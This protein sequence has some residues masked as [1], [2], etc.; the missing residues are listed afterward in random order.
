M[1]TIG[2]SLPEN[3][4]SSLSLANNTVIGAFDA[5]KK[6]FHVA[7]KV[8]DEISE[9]L[10]YIID[11]NPKPP[12]DYN[13]QNDKIKGIVTHKALYPTILNKNIKTPNANW[14]NMY[15]EHDGPLAKNL[16]LITPIVHD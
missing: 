4:S 16:E 1:R 15:G 12:D 8:F 5:Y 3:E 9:P 13:T 14:V 2:Y 6:E 7:S 11:L 10:G